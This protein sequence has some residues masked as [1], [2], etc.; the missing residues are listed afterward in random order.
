MLVGDRALL[1]VIKC[2]VDCV[3]TML[4]AGKPAGIVDGERLDAVLLLR[5]CARLRE[6]LDVDDAAVLRVDQMLREVTVAPPDA[7]CWAAV[8]IVLGTHEA[9]LREQLGLVEAA[10]VLLPR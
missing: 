8:R 3:E 1:L 7:A 9:F 2:C 4:L 6:L 10:R 5:A